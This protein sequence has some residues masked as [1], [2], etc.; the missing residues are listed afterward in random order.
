M[1]LRHCII[2]ALV[3]HL[4]IARGHYILYSDTSHS[5]LRSSL[6]QMQRGQPHYI[7]CAIKSLPSA[8]QYCSVTELEMTGLMVSIFL[9]PHLFYHTDFACCVCYIAIAQILK[10]KALPI[11]QRIGRYLELLSNYSFNL[12]YPKGKDPNL[13]DFL[14]QIAVD[15]SRPH[16]ITPISFT[17]KDQLQ[18][19]YH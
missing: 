11:S 10:S 6:W 8:C 3:L 9:W 4:P 7:G 5:H 2:K 17:L 19:Y 1:E 13:S 16:E 14:S 15:D 12:Y 18:E